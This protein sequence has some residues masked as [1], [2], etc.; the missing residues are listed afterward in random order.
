M[1]GKIKKKKKSNVETTLALPTV[2]WLTLLDGVGINKF[3]NL[4]LSNLLSIWLKPG[5]WDT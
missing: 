4:Y 3:R 2:C 5:E 1:E